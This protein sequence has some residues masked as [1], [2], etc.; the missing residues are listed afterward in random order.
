MQR[1]HDQDEAV[2]CHRLDHPGPNKKEQPPPPGLKIIKGECDLCTWCKA[3]NGTALGG[4]P[5][6][7][8]WW[9]G[10]PPNWEQRCKQRVGSSSNPCI[11]H[12]IV[13]RARAKGLLKAQWFISTLRRSYNG[14]RGP[15]QWRG[16]A[17]GNGAVT[18]CD[19][20]GGE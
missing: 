13:L 1:C 8:E 19:Q 20:N 15:C 7:G 12:E 17:K 16:V 2:E 3:G 11:G 10:D 5:V 9:L 6:F 14:T 4:V 18:D